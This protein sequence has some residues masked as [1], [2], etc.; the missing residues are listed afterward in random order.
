MG[1]SDLDMLTIEEYMAL[2]QGNRRSGVIFPE[3]NKNIN[4]EI[5]SQF[6]KELGLK[7]FAGTEDENAHLHVQRVL[8]IADLFHTPGVTQDALMLRVF[9]ITLTGAARR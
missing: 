4:F 3:I 2:T 9:P 5:S 1:D 8:E 7:L 6:L